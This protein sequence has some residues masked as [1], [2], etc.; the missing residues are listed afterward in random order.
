MVELT[1]I[2][3]DAWSMTSI[4]ERM[5]GRPEVAPWLRGIAEELPQTA[6]AWRAELDLFRDHAISERALKAVFTAH[7]IRAHESLTTN[8]FR[9]VDFLK[10]AVKSNAGIHDTRVVVRRPRDVTILTVGELIKDSGILNTDPTL[11][12]PASFGGLDKGLLSSDAIHSPL[13]PDEPDFQSLDVAD[14]SG[15]ES[16][17]DARPRLRLLIKR[18]EEGWKPLPLPGGEP[19]PADLNLEPVYETPKAIFN[20]IERSQLRVRLVHPLELDEEETAVRSLVLLAP[21]GS[22]LKPEKQT[23]DEHV[24]YVEAEARR[25]EKRCGLDDPIRA[26]L[27]FAAMWHDEGKKADV[28][29]HFI[30]RTTNEPL[31]GKAATTRDPKSLRGYRHEFGSL[32]RIH[33]PERHSTDCE[34]PVD[35][36]IRDLALHLIATHHGFSRP[37][38][39]NVFDRDFRTEDRE[40]LHTEV[41]RR[42]ARLQRKYGWWQLAWLENLLRCADA[43]ASADPDA[44][45]T[46][47]GDGGE[48]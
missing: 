23:L 32:L 21:V 2:L 29:Q 17:E 43:L 25:I 35:A 26:A 3:L 7:R 20:A 1:D 38:F 18:T 11:I 46:A 44:D 40:T 8:S 47:D 30:G 19:I 45:D 48:T 16:R 24:G 33:H 10:Q 9:V 27:L 22:K 31:L 39:N 37:H 15:Y 13:K 42:F 41:I 4:T 28:W 6:I 5:P 34:L 12:L 36:E 14:K